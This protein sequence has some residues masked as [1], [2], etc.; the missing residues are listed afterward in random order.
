MKIRSL[1]QGVHKR[2][3]VLSV[4]NKDGFSGN[5]IIPMGGSSYFAGFR[6]S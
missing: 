1:P 6:L 3:D 2:D 5:E 4:I